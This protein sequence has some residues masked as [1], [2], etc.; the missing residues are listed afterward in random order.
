ME[1]CTL[2]LENVISDYLNFF[3]TKGLPIHTARVELTSLITTLFHVPLNSGSDVFTSEKYMY[4]ANVKPMTDSPSSPIQLPIGCQLTI[5]PDNEIQV[6]CPFHSS[7]DRQITSY[8]T[9]GL[10]LSNTVLSFNGFTFSLGIQVPLQSD[11][12]CGLISLV[13]KLRICN[14]VTVVNAG[15]DTKIEHV[16]TCERIFLP[17]SR[18]MSC[19]SCV[20]LKSLQEGITNIWQVVKT[21]QISS[22]EHTHIVENTCLP[23]KNESNFAEIQFASHDELLEQ[24]TVSDRD[25]QHV[26]VD[27]EDSLKYCNELSGIEHLNERRETELPLTADSNDIS[28]FDGVFLTNGLNM[29]ATLE[30]RLGT[31]VFDGTNQTKLL[32]QEQTH[33]DRVLDECGSSKENSRTVMIEDRSEEKMTDSD[34]QIEEDGDSNMRSDDDEFETLKPVRNLTHCFVSDSSFEKF[35]IP[36]HGDH[37]FI[38]N[39][40]TARSNLVV[41]E[42]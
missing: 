30:E 36:E 21:R 31:D 29:T 6:S 39:Y 1:T 19:E 25:S 37:L 20:N 17:L 42:F 4:F 15:G 28:E 7:G 35:Y 40:F 5:T 10:Q 33:T 34:G 12:I 32:N 27:A 14:G 3:K 23:D 41:C 18:E 8:C 13:G 22:L 9:I 11:R 26:F 2:L 16:G 38:M 24:S